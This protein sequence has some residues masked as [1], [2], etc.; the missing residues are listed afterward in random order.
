MLRTCG[1]ALAKRAWASPELAPDRR[2]AGCI[3]QAREGA[4]HQHV[5]AHLDA[6]QGEAADIDDAAWRCEARLP[7]R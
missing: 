6:V 4:D 1:E 3:G 2:M 7:E 5:V